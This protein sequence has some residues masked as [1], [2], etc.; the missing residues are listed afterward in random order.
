MNLCQDEAARSLPTQRARKLR[1][2]P[3]ILYYAQESAREEGATLTPIGCECGRR[4]RDG[5][6]VGPLRPFDLVLKAGCVWLRTP[7]SAELYEWE[8]STS[9]GPGK[10]RGSLG[11]LT[12]PWPGRCLHNINYQTF[13]FVRWPRVIP[14]T[15][16][17]RL[18]AAQQGCAEPKRNQACA[19]QIGLRICGVLRRTALS[20]APQVEAR[21]N[22]GF[23]ARRFT[24]WLCPNCP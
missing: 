4:P 20:L 6:G 14:Q 8:D 23:Q 1:F 10:D 18:P 2:N 17:G 22:I 15:C 16:F 13:T 24:L 3:C 11:Q 19:L 21:A 9:L 5:D 7:K 12:G